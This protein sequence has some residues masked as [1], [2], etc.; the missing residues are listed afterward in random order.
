MQS[1]PATSEDAPSRRCIITSSWER[2]EGERYSKVI[3]PSGPHPRGAGHF[4]SWG[5]SCG[6]GFQRGMVPSS[7]RSGKRTQRFLRCEER[8]KRR[9]ELL[10]RG[11]IDLAVRAIHFL[12]GIAVGPSAAGPVLLPQATDA[13]SDVPPLVSGEVDAE[14]PQDKP[15]ASDLA[16]L[17]SCK[18]DWTALCGAK[19]YPYRRVLSKP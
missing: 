7:D 13:R 14:T 18:A 19:K 11:Q 5:F 4:L 16:P 9:H 17:V 1:L 6:T 15:P 12:S 8:F 10:S 2:H 3:L